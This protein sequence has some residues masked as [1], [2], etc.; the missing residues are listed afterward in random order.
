[1]ELQS[2]LKSTFSLLQE[3]RENLEPRLTVNEVGSV[4]FISQSIAWVTGL[5]GVKAEEILLFEGG[6]RGIAFNIDADE[7]GVILLGESTFLKAGSDV[8]RTGE[9]L[10]VPVGEKLIGRVVD[11]LGEP[12][13]HGPAIVT[14]QRRPIE[15]EAPGI[16]QRSPVVTPL[17]TGVK[18]IDALIPIGKGQREL[19]LGDRQSGKTALAID[20]IINQ[21]DKDVICIYC[22]IGQQNSAVARIIAELKSHG[23]M[24]YSIV[25]ATAGESPPG[26]Q[27]I[28]PY[29]A[30]TMA[31]HFMNKGLDALVVFDDLTK[32]AWAYREISLLLNRPPG[33]EAYPGDIFYI[34]SRLLERSTHL[35]KELGGGSLTALP[36]VEVEAQNI[37]AYIPTNLISITDGQIYLSP[38]LFERGVLPAVDVGKSV[39]RVG[40]KT[41]F[42]T[43]RKIAGDLRL[44]YS[45]F[46]ELESFVKFGTRLDAKTQ[47]TI[48]H[49]KRVRE[50]LKQHLHDT[51]SAAQ[52]IAIFIALNHGIL[53]GVDLEDIVDVEKNICATFHRE[54]P[55][56]YKK[57]NCGENITEEEVQQIV[58]IAKAVVD[59]DDHGKYE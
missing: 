27:F 1:M 59:G 39:S 37:S 4:K 56:I 49:G 22:T 12:I 26:L 47:E 6:L 50:V 35:R 21:C 44:A 8:Y 15:A 18:V 9:I 25:V 30:M 5:R 43:Y 16:M 34:H 52:Q 57:I 51:L 38:S 40:G 17:F 41:Q 53:D 46:E 29:A 54:L 28:A 33:R 14:L 20:T 23:A 48:H 2:L 19:I 31:E 10:Q 24:S 32:H 3:T 11:A 36:I 7:V 55:K 42:P 58:D 45:Q 13:D